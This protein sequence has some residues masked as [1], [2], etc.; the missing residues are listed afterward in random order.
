M[1]E[2]HL[3]II[4]FNIP[5]PPNYGGVIDVFY[6]IKALHSAGIKIHLHCFEYGREIPE[7]LEKLCCEIFY[8]SRKTGVYS[9]ISYKPYIVQSRKSESLIKNLLK[10]KYP[11][12][13]EGMHCCYYLNDK[14]LTDRLKIYRESNIE[15]IYYYHLFKSEKNQFKKIYFL[16]EA[17]KLKMFQRI[18]KHADLI[19][20]VSKSECEYLQNKFRFNKVVYLPSFHSNE[21]INIKAGFGNYALYHGNLSV[22]ENEEAAIYLCNNIFNDIEVPLIISGLQPS[23]RLK[24]EISKYKNIKLISNPDEAEMNN[25][26]SDA[27]IHVLISFQETGLK[28]KLLNTLYNGR[29]CVVNEKILAGTNLQSLCHIGNNDIDLKKII[30]QLFHTEFNNLEIEKRENIIT[31]NYS[32][33]SNLKKLIDLIFI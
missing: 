8:Y 17:I 21:K 29:Y 22:P 11:I 26:I 5:Y 33:K 9:S 18:L 13:F 15:H 2:N 1:L 12:L 25:L 20:V 28:L 27:Q 16:I 10:D 30:I 6:K 7:E 3:H 14:R 19:L 23:K 24:T 32:N 4:S 31:E